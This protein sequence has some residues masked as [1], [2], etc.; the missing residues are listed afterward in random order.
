MLFLII[1][2]AAAFF[3]LSVNVGQK[4]LNLFLIDRSI[5]VWDVIF[6]FN[7]QSFLSDNYVFTQMEFLK[8]KQR[9]LLLKFFSSLLLLGLVA[10]D[11]TICKYIEYAIKHWPILRFYIFVSSAG[12]SFEHKFDLAFSLEIQFIKPN[13]HNPRF[14]L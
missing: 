10:L 9:S 12:F 13:L 2:F 11:S 4:L 1:C 5:F 7:L 14:W 8:V 6:V 3:H